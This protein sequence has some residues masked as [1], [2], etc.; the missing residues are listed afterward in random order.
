MSVNSVA[1]THRLGELQSLELPLVGAVPDRPTTFQPLEDAGCQWLLDAMGE[2]I[3]ATT[4]RQAAAAQMG[5]DHSQMTKQ[6]KG[7]GHFSLKRA[8]ALDRETLIGFAD[9][10]R[11]HFGCN[12]DPKEAARQDAEAIAKALV[13]LVARVR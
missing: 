12:E 10:I 3:D 11:V 5:V 13:R 7:E 1:K 8:A 2:A 4:K 6:L 9:R